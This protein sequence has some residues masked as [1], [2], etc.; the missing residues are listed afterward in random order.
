MINRNI[1]GFLD[2]FL[3]PTGKKIEI[4]SRKSLAKFGK[5]F[6]PDNQK[7]VLSN[8]GFIHYL[9]FPNRLGDMG[10]K[11]IESGLFW[12]QNSLYWF[13][14]RFDEILFLFGQ[15]YYIGLFTDFCLL[16]F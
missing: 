7:K 9:D 6:F 1:F 3:G 16:L 13:L 8:F 12:V 2:F 4:L 11:R 15:L 5:F 10:E 14:L